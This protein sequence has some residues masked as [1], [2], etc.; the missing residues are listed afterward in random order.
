MLLQHWRNAM[1]NDIQVINGT[2]RYLLAGLGPRITHDIDNFL[3]LCLAR[4]FS[5]KTARAY[6][7]DFLYFFRW[8]EE[9][10]LSFKKINIKNMI[11]F[12]AY[13][14]KND[15]GASSINRRL[16]TIDQFFRFCYGDHIQNPGSMAHT[17]KSKVSF[18]TYDSLLGIHPIK[19]RSYAYL[20]VKGTQKLIVALESDEV[21]KF[22]KTLITKRDIAIF[23]LMLFCGLRSCEVMELQLENINRI[24]STVLVLGKGKRQRHVPMSADVMKALDNYIDTERP[25]RAKTDH[26]FLALK[27]PKRGM[28]LTA[29]GFRSI[30]RYKRAT[31]GVTHA[32]PHRFRHTFARNMAATGMPLPI[33]QILVGHNDPRT[34]LKYINLT[35][36]DVRKDFLKAMQEVEKN[37]GKSIF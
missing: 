16:I 7:Y 31:S 35:Q 32:N 17:G 25:A 6:A 36:L 24:D 26:V 4:G 30:F 29:E 34:T 21:A 12:I 19:R 18:L 20:K 10:K 15:A 23:Y 1:N 9:K 22:F 11:E 33:L 2:H 5:E 3:N 13:Q 8:L 14:Q 37:Y 27:G 28:A